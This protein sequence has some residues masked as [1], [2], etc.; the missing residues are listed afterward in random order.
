MFGTLLAELAQAFPRVFVQEA[1]R[2]VEGRAAP[3]FEARRGSGVRRATA[4][5]TASMS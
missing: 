2:G 1:H 4:S 3:H 5:A